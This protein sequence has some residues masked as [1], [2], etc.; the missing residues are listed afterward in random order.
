[1]AD[2][3]SVRL[4]KAKLDHARVTEQLAEQTKLAATSI[5]ALR[6]LGY[7]TVAQASSAAQALEAEVEQILATTEARLLEVRSS[8][9]P[10]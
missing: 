2:T 8:L 4:E 6:G 10:K 7:T 9:E 5:E 1:M 3:L